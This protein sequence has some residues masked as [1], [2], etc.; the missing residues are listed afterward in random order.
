MI[1][2]GFDRFSNDHRKFK[3]N[4]KHVYI[5]FL[6]HIITNRVDKHGINKTE[7]INVKI[8]REKKNSEN[9]KK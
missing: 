4:G 2:L 9:R 3:K 1:R 7:S 6:C 5:L 8:K